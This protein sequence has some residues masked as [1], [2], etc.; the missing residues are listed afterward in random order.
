MVLVDCAEMKT[1]GVSSYLILEII[2]LSGRGDC[3]TLARSIG[4]K[5]GTRKTNS[6][7]CL[8]LYSHIQVSFAKRGSG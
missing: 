2:D 1:V 7:N 8:K 4:V 3:D 6:S 5:F